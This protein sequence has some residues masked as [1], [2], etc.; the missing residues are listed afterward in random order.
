MYRFFRELC[1]K[2]LRIPPEPEPPPV[3]ENSARVFRAAPKY[4]KYLRVMWGI[5]NGVALLAVMIPLT[6]ISIALAANR[7]GTAAA[8][9]ANATLRQGLVGR[10]RHRSGHRQN[11]RFPY[12][13]I[14]SAARRG[15][16]PTS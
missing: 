3:D 16:T 15:C 14:R 4:L 9:R 7:E 13:P 11:R 6:V 5:R 2:W 10:P 1:E 12:A 8:V